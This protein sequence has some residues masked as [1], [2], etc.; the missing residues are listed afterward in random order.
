MKIVKQ[1]AELMSHNLPT[2]KFIEKV[3][4]ICYK[5]EDKITED[6]ALGLVNGLIR[7]NHWAMLENEYIY[8]KVD[9]NAYINIVDDIPPQYLKY[10]NFD[11]PYVSGSIRAWM[12]LYQNAKS[13]TD[14]NTDVIGEIFYQLSLKYPLFFE[15]LDRPIISYGVEVITREEIEDVYRLYTQP[16]PLLPH[17]IKFTTP[18]AI[19][20]ELVRHRVASFLV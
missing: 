13:F 9:A 10:L 3:A 6:S 1:N 17:T 12:E 14:M 18:R 4:R 20:N 5:S 11:I 2:E 15:M 16:S 7:S 19:A 8:I